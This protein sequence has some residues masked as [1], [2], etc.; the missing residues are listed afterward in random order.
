MVVLAIE[1]AQRLLNSFEKNW[2]MAFHMLV[3]EFVELPYGM[4]TAG[5]VMV[6]GIVTCWEVVGDVLAADVVLLSEV[7]RMETWL[8][9]EVVCWVV[10]ETVD[11]TVE[12]VVGTVVRIVVV[13][14]VVGTEVDGTVETLVDKVLVEV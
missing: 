10:V 11:W 8:V 3:M 14:V 7:D 1:A 6:A 4:V 5:M 12:L 2:V 9:T 13:A